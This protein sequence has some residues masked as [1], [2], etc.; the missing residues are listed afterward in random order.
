MGNGESETN[1]NNLLSQ[2]TSDYSTDRAEFGVATAGEIFRNEITRNV[3]FCRHLLLELE[4]L[5]RISVVMGTARIGSILV[6]ECLQGCI[7]EGWQ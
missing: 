4:E 3:A 1:L 7:L 6:P 5:V 2:Y